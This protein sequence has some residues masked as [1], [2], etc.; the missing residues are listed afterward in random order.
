[1]IKA[2]D[3][4]VCNCSGCKGEFRKEAWIVEMHKALDR[5]MTINED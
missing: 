5:E 1:M 4:V 3:V 2:T